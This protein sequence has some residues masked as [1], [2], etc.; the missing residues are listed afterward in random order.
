MKAPLFRVFSIFC[1]L[2]FSSLLAF[3]SRPANSQLHRS[4]LVSCQMQ[5]LIITHRVW[6]AKGYHV[7]RSITSSTYRCVKTVFSVSSRRV[8][9]VQ[10]YFRRWKN[11]QMN[12]FSAKRKT[13]QRHSTEIVLF[14]T[15]SFFYLFKLLLYECYF[16]VEWKFAFICQS[17]QQ[18]TL[19][20][21][22]IASI[23]N[24]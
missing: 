20:I 16:S 9:A 11:Y 5:F 6:Q 23:Q 7:P 2:L 18:R 10:R 13:T 15:K 14:P 8:A 17:Y 21:G 1:Y 3:F 12:M 19:I 22:S 4:T 24:L